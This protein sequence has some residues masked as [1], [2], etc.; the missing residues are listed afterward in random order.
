MSRAV[1]AQQR[2]QWC[3]VRGHRH[4]SL[5]ACHAGHVQAR[6]E[7]GRGAPGNAL[8][9]ILLTGYR[10]RPLSQADDLTRPGV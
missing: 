9:V 10:H 2:E 7:A 8:D 6:A 1:R 4:Q 3:P 5:V